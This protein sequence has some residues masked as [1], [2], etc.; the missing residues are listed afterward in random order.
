[1]G[2]TPAVF[3]CNKVMGVRTPPGL[4]KSIPFVNE[5][6]PYT[7]D[8]TLMDALQ[9]ALTPPQGVNASLSKLSRMNVSAWSQRVSP[10]PI[11]SIDI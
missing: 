2:P 11:A 6:S 10:R 7:Y 5:N 1:M 3:D 9:D 4:C 8:F